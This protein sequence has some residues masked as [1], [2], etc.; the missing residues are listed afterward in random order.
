M[1]LL[2]LDSRNSNTSRSHKLC[3]EVKLEFSAHLMAKLISVLK[4]SY[5][6]WEGGPDTV[7]K[8]LLIDMVGI[9]IA[10]AM[11]IPYFRAF[12]MPWTRTRAFDAFAV[13]SVKMGG[14]CNYMTYTIFDTLF[15]KATEVQ[16]NRWQERHLRLRGTNWDKMQVNKVPFLYNFSVSRPLDW[17]DWTTV[18]GYWFLDESESSTEKIWEPP[19]DVINFIAKARAD[20]KKIVYIGFGSIVVSDSKAFTE[21]VIKSVVNGWSSMYSI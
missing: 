7:T 21:I 3:V 1:R 14:L 20:E 5:P 10:E 11:K 2:K 8:N 12:T 16:I 18:T 13:P 17:G 6:Q 4:F 15:W 19:D 9:H